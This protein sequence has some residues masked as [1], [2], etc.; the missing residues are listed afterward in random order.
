LA[1][2]GIFCLLPAVITLSKLVYSCLWE[3]FSIATFLIGAI[4]PFA[5][6]ARMTLA[7]LGPG[8]K[9]FKTF[10]S[11]INSMFVAGVSDEFV[12]VF[13]ESY[14]Q[15]RWVG[16]IWLLFLVIVHVLL[17]SL[18][19]D[20]LV[21]AYMLFSEKHAED[22][23]VRKVG[24]ML[25]VFQVLTD[26]TSPG[27]F[28]ATAEMA[29]TQAGFL[30]FIKE[31][32]ASAKIFP[33]DVQQANFMFKA[34]DMDDSGH[35]DLEEFCGVCRVIQYKY[36]CTRQFSFIKDRFP[37]F[38]KSASFMRFRQFVQGQGAV[39]AGDGD[40]LVKADIDDS[41]GEGQL[42]SSSIDEPSGLEGVMNVV[43][44][45]NLA[46]VIVETI[47]DL[48]QS[49]EPPCFEWLELAF[50]FIYLV[51]VGAKLAVVS[52]KEYWSCSSNQ[53]DFL[54]TMLLLCTSLLESLLPDDVSTYANML[55]LLRLFRVVKQL[56]K[57]D[58]VQFMVKTITKLLQTASEMVTMLGV[59]VFFFTMLSVQTLGGE[60]YE[61]NKK[62]EET[63]YLEGHM[64]VLNCNDVPMAFGVWV[65]M[66]LQEYQPA[67]P[68]AVAKVAPWHCMWLIFPIFY[69]VAVSIVFELVK[70]FTIEVF[71]V[72]FNERMKGNSIRKHKD[73]FQLCLSGF[74]EAL[75]A[76]GL[77]LHFQYESLG[78]AQKEM[79]AAFE[80]LAEHA[81]ALP[82]SRERLASMLKMAEG[83]PSHGHGHGHH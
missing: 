65:V 13:L 21:A 45:M 14:T 66:L 10:P 32:T 29:V 31:Y 5:W 33:I 54:S 82:T 28:S 3:F 74:K 63:E 60:L 73:S 22:I 24:G 57:L 76:K 48:N 4:V 12:A 81:K 47:F 42:N 62:L 80:E 79:Q 58:S 70:A 69:V 26:C 16:I 20:T 71:I 83:G 6:L 25:T 53:F 64:M 9:G 17:L 30:D 34:I 7:D 51:E 23:A 72:L 11:A 61:D 36:W 75:Q 18:V 67:F 59:V 27:E 50:S 39:I 78:E 77:S 19:L 52:F 44:L 49:P 46:L 15:Y 38:W 56:K 41:D 37:A 43:L 35:I 55:R 1:R 8:S 40:F 2:T 68:D